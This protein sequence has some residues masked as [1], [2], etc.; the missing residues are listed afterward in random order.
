MSDIVGSADAVTSLYPEWSRLPQSAPA[1]STVSMPIL[2]PVRAGAVDGLQLLFLFHPDYT[3]T[4][5]GFVAVAET[6][7]RQILPHR[8]LSGASGWTPMYESVEDNPYLSDF[9]RIATL[10]FSAAG[11][12]PLQPVPLS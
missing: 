3:M 9:Y 10:V 6:S 11:L 2:Y 8:L 5:R 1:A 4:R 12:F 7:D